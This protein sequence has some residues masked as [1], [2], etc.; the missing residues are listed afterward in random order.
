M[1]SLLAPVFAWSSLGFF[2][3]CLFSWFFGSS[4]VMFLCFWVVCRVVCLFGF[5]LI[6]C[7]LGLFFL[8]NS[9]C[10]KGM[11]LFVLG[12][13]VEPSL[14]VYPWDAKGSDFS[15]RPLIAKKAS[16]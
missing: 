6:F 15:V 14:H 1:S 16:H 10:A 7:V 12:V 3:G 13:V 5:G 2:V 11:H 9:D 4:C 8:S